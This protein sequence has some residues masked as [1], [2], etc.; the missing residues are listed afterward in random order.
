MIFNR[1]PLLRHIFRTADPDQTDRIAAE[2]ARRWRQAF[3]D[4]PELANDLIRQ[5]GLLTLLPEIYD[6]GKKTPRD[7]DPLRLAYFTGQ[8]DLAIKLLAMGGITY[9]ELNQLMETQNV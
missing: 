9:H 3:G 6:E 8:R 7:I 1:M 2:H 4:Q 5:G